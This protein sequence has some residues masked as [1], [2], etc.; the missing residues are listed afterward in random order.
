MSAAPVKPS[1]IKPPT[2]RLARPSV[3]S[4]PSSNGSSGENIAGRSNEDL[5]KKKIS[6]AS[7]VLT[8]DT[9]SFI[10]GQRIYVNGVKPGVIQFIGETKFAP[11]EWAGIVLDD[12]SGKNDGSVGGVR[13]FQC[14]PK[15]GVFSRLTRLTRQPLDAIQL[16]ALQTQQTQ[17]AATNEN[18][19]ESLVGSTNSIGANGSNLASPVAATQNS[20]VSVQ[21]IGDLRLGDRVIVTPPRREHRFHWNP[22]RWCSTFSGW[23]YVA[24]CF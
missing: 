3:T 6:D 23:C 19:D 11:G 18:G 5:A 22:K 4:K 21:S 2:S 7:I 1:G 10:I 16:A 8:T 14:Q 12:L 15:K 17:P 9:D 20:V 13:Y 24:L